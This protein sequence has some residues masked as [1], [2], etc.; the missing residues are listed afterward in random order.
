MEPERERV[1][2]ID[3]LRGFDMLWIV[4]GDHFMRSLGKI[5]DSPVASFLST[6]CKHVAWEGFRFYDLIFPLFVFLLGMSV[7]FSLERYAAGGERPPYARI[8]RRFATIFLVGAFCDMGISDLAHESPFA[9]VLQRMAWCYLFASLLYTHLKPRNLVIVWVA[10]LVGYWGLLTFVAAPGQPVVSFEPEKNITAWFDYQFLPLKEDGQY[11]DSEGLLS[12][13]PAVASAM[14]GVFAG[15]LM[16]NKSVSEM[17][18]V[19]Y[20]LGAGLVLLAAGYLLGFQTPIIK[21]IWTTSFVFVAGGYSC[22]LTGLFYWVVDVKKVRWWTSP[23]V[24]IGMNPLA[25][26]A[27]AH[28]IDFH[29]MANR[30][31]GGPVAEAFGQFGPLL[32]TLGGTAAV[33]FLA[34]FLYKRQI[35]LRA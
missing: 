9:G 19:A 20:F 35:F 21:K 7:V 13:V 34:R 8:F 14:L 18:R 6:Q 27:C 1:V 17:R 30:F 23:F 11:S 33:I 12:T 28:V 26:Y 16:R 22:V 2:S 15:L 24:W 32:V 3:T 4:G 5:S 10:I 29:G 25:I 31:L